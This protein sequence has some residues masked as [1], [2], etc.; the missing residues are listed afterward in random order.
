MTKRLLTAIRSLPEDYV[1]DD[2]ELCEYNGWVVAVNGKVPLPPIKYQA[3]SGWSK[4]T[5]ADTLGNL[6]DSRP[7]QGQTAPHSP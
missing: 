2:T 6:L 1:A 3:A 4:V 7:K 5:F